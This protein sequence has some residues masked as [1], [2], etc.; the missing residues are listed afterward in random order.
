MSDLPVTRKLT[1]NEIIVLAYR[2]CER[3]LASE[4]FEWEEI[5][6]LGQYDCEQVAE[7]MGIVCNYLRDA[8]R[9]METTWNIDSSTLL[10]E[11]S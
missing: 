9:L 4:W 3:E 1:D 5:P 6:M 2:L 10:E 11:L 7:K 8:R